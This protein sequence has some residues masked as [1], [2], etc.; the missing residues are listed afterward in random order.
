MK[1]RIKIGLSLAALLFLILIIIFYL[2]VQYRTGP[3][4]TK[5]FAALLPPDTAAIASIRNFSLLWNQASSLKVYSQIT[6]SRELATLLLS[7]DDIRDWK[8]NL[9][10]I[11]YKTRMEIGRDFILKW[12]GQDAAIAL[13]SPPSKNASPAIL[14]MSKT[15]IGFEEK[16]AELVALYYPDLKLEGKN[17]CGTVINTYQGKKP[18]RSFCYIRFGRTVILSLRSSEKYALEKIIDLKTDETLPRLFDTPN[19]RKYLSSLK[20]SSGVSAFVQSEYLVSFLESSGKKSESENL[21]EWL[22]NIQTVTSPYSWIHMNFHLENG[23]KGELGF[24]FAKIPED[25]P[26]PPPAEFQSLKKL[27]KETCAFLGIKD[28]N[29][30]EILKWTSNLILPQDSPDQT[31]DLNTELNRILKKRLFSHVKNEMLVSLE[32]MEPGLIYP[33]FNA[34]LFLELKDPEKAKAEIKDIFSGFGAERGENQ[35]LGTP[36][37]MIG[38]SPE[39]DFIRFKLRGN[40]EVM[41]KQEKSAPLSSHPLYQ[42]LFPSSPED[43]RVVLYINFERVSQDLEE[44]SKRSIRW[45]KKTRERVKRWQKWAA[46]CR[47]LKGCAMWDERNQEAITYTICIPVE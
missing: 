13:I 42:N 26:M 9:T 18:S 7:S 12:L 46:V 33:L 10:E 44:L 11:E 15:R 24:H 14:V 5:H 3:D 22:P 25:S 38:Y 39:D 29:L 35:I 17:Y 21:E 36:L 6:E 27:P 43:S 41:V 40:P 28:Q 31:P 37:G 45:N 16:L 8:K 2:V 30:D 34:D 47:F 32:K 4:F 23:F 19:F 1:K 20:Q